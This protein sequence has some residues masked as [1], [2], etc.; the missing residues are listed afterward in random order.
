MEIKSVSGVIPVLLGLFIFGIGYN[1]LVAWLIH[2]GYDEGYMWVIVSI[3]CVA[4][5]LGL[6]IISPMA[7][8]LAMITFTASGL[9]MAAGSWWRHVRSRKAAQDSTR[10]EVL[11]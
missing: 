6:A 5:L 2:H 3:G 7:A 10:S 11:R 1:T 8:L 4:T 9:P